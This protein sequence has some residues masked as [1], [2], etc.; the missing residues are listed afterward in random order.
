MWF[1]DRELDD[2]HATMGQIG[3]HEGAVIELF[4]ADESDPT[5]LAKFDKK[6]SH[7]RKRQ[8]SQRSEGFS[9]TGLHG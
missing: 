4:E 7:P 2:N 5:K 9:A 3:I 6:E 8:K 1:R